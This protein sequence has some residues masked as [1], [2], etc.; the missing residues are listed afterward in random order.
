MVP[1]CSKLYAR[2]ICLGLRHLDPRHVPSP[3]GRAFDDAVKG[4]LVG[5]R[6]CV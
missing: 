3:L 6:L 5:A 1:F 2:A 4:Y